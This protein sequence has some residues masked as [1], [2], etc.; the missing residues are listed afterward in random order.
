MVL[1]MMIMVMLRIIVQIENI[2]GE[3]IVISGAKMLLLDFQCPI[4]LVRLCFL[5]LCVF[6][7][8]K[9]C[10]FVVSFNAQ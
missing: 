1:L 3:D 9:Q 7:M 4:F 8:V 10:V 5:S 2:S 6:K